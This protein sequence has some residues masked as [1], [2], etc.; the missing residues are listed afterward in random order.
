M[1]KMSPDNIVNTFHSFF[2]KNA[3]REMLSPSNSIRLF[4][5]IDFGDRLED[6][7]VLS[8]EFLWVSSQDLRNMA[9]RIKDL[10]EGSILFSFKF[11]K[12]HITRLRFLKQLFERAINSLTP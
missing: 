10:K 11:E 4:T 2:V 3:G 6:V 1:K 12:S 7:L 9:M 8:R 5:E